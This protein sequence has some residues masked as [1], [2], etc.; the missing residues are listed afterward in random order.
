[1]AVPCVKQ[2]THVSVSGWEGSQVSSVVDC[3]AFQPVSFCSVVTVL[4]FPFSI[5]FGSVLEEK[6]R[7]RFRFRFYS[8]CR[9][10]QST[11][12]EMRCTGRDVLYALDRHI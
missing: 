8:H 11:R 3:W 7:F 10:G 1:M 6:P 2:T 5:G 9:V 4:D 12:Q